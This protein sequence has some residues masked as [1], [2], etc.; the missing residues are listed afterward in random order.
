MLLSFCNYNKE[1]ICAI[2]NNFYF[3]NKCIFKSLIKAFSLIFEKTKSYILLTTIL[4]YK[5]SFYLDIYV[6]F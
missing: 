5:R 2:S 1:Y 3:A 6:F 4:I